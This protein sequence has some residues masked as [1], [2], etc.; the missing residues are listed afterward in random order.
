M[1][2]ARGVYVW[3]AGRFWSVEELVP[4]GRASERETVQRRAAPSREEM[5]GGD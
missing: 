4:E 1:I 5:I 3:H 2:K